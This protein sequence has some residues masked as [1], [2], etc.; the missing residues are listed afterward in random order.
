M[1]YTPYVPKTVDELGDMLGFIA[2]LAPK[3]EDPMFP[4]RNVS[5]VFEQLNKALDLLRSKIGE[6]KFRALSQLSQ[7]MRA[8]FD[9]DPEDED[10]AARVGRAIAHKMQSILRGG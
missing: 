1:T 9:A 2:I 6:E 3:F 7:E 4:G 8:H 10:G 5:S